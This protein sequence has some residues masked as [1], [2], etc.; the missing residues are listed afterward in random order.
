MIKVKLQ[1]L[2][3][4]EERSLSWVALKTNIAYTTLHKFSNNKTSSV[5]YNVLE[6]LCGL[7]KCKIEDIIEYDEQPLNIK[8]KRG[9]EFIH[10]YNK[11]D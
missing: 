11:K 9:D 10:E 8:I 3:D 2:L 5:S 7:F 1:D 4:R 6:S